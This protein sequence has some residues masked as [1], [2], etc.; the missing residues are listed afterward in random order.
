[1]S[2]ATVI[3]QLR[4][5]LV[6]AEN[7]PSKFSKVYPSDDQWGTLSDLSVRLLEA[8]KQI[9]KDI[10]VLMESRTE[11]AWEESKAHRS[12]APM[13]TGELLKTGR[14]KHAPVFRRNIVT[15][16]EGPKDSSFDTEDARIRKVAT[17]KRCELIRGLSPD[18]V[19]SWAIAFAPSLWAGGMMASDVFNCLL[20]DIEPEMAQTWPPII[21]DTLYTLRKEE[22]SLKKCS[23]YDNLLQG[24]PTK[25]VYAM[26]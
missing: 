4:G 5:L 20:G 24:Q 15:I 10:R 2:A 16:F 7:L 13:L 1:M 26:Y 11:R 9:E 25:I 19:V 17:R 18:G 12:N 14:L 22:E 6:K 21:R 23:E 8:A 3:S